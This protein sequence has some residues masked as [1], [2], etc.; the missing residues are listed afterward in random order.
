MK[1]TRQLYCQYLLSSQI[2]YTCTNLA[3]HFEDLDHNS[4]YRYL[5]TERLTPRLLWEKVRDQIVYSPDGAI[6]FDDTVLDKSYS[7]AI[8]GVRRQYSGN[9][10]A[11]IKGIGLVNCVYYNPDI[12]RF[13]V[14]DYRIFD[15]DRDGK[16]KLDHV[17]EM[18]DMLGFREVEYHF[19]LMDSWYATMP[20]MT[21]LIKEQ[22][23]FYCPLKKNRLVDDSGGEK[24]YRAIENLVWTADEFQ[25]GKTVKV[26]KFAGSTHL[27]MFRVVV[28]TSRTDYIVTNDVTQS[29]TDD[30]Q[31][32]SGQRW[33]TSAISPRS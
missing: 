29:D 7:F 27:K 26:K 5:K 9:E 19:V 24:P 12:D 30:A 25:C 21:R 31:Q 32:V 3:E 15:P 11:V 4:V 28:E 17:S 20:L 14:L 8:E 10:H 23:I 2:N 22:K 18:L 6:I 16:T 33:K 1:T 13:W